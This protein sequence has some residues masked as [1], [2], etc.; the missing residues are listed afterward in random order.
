MTGGR[1]EKV[2]TVE[3]AYETHKGTDEEYQ[4]ISVQ[5]LMRI[6][7]TAVPKDQA[8]WVLCSTYNAPDGR[9]HRAQEERGSFVMVAVDLDTGNVQGKALV[10][11]VQSFTGKVQMRVYSSSS[12]TKDERK[13]RVLI[14]LCVAHE[15]PAWLAITTALNEHILESIGVR[16]D[17]ALERAGQPI[18]LPN[19]APRTDGVAPLIADN[20]IEGPRLDV[21][22][23][24][25]LDRINAVLQ[26]ESERQAEHAKRSAEARKRMAQMRA[27]PGNQDKSVISEFNAANDLE[28]VLA[29]CGYRPG[30]RGGWKSPHQQTASYATKVFDEPSGQYWVSLSQ[31]DLAAGVGSQTHDGRSCFGDAFDVWAFH[32]HANNRTQAIKAAADELG[33]KPPPTDIDRLAERIRA[34]QLARMQ[35]TATLA[36]AEVAI[37]GA[38][39]AAV[40]VEFPEEKQDSS[41][42]PGKAAAMP[43]KGETP[44][45]EEQS[46]TRT[47]PYIQASDL[48]GWE[49]PREL[50]EG[51]L[52]EGGMTVI[53]GDSNTGKSFL[54][55]DMAAHVSL[56]RNWFGRRVKQGAVVYLAAESP[57]SIIDRSRALADKIGQPLDNLFITNCPI[58]LHDKNGDVLAVVNTI[59][60]IEKRYG[61]KVC[62]V[63]ADTL[64]RVMGAGDEN[65]TKDMGVLVQHVDAIRAAIGVQFVLIHHTGKDASKGA[66]G[67]SALRAA[68]DTEIEVSDPGNDGPKEFKVTKQ[69]DLEGKGEVYGFTLS[70]VKLGVGVFDN[71]VTT[72]Y[73]QQAEPVAADPLAGLKDGE[74]EIVETIRAS[75]VGGV[76]YGELVN[77]IE[78]VSKVT[79]KRY[80]RSLRNKGLI[81]EQSGQYRL[82]SGKD[83]LNFGISGKEF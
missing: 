37:E 74:L 62:M 3:G 63:V 14:P 19:T 18:Y 46:I 47:L 31:S 24:P 34:N 70:S 61:V 45:A 33:I 58:D 17:Q 82:G 42:G 12:A 36:A 72:C 4:T 16:P 35:A 80:I 20:L 44:A 77:A 81:Y 71:V 67:S 55:L 43:V 64:A 57:R 79:V 54:T 68:T 75:P 50:I 78:G 26:R 28:Q 13:W 76:R 52:I 11:A 53:Y 23:C 2:L 15:F 29:A 48:P 21:Y 38:T 69:R 5:E 66:R 10:A 59:D 51:M 83:G 30:P 60:A 65:A 41:P 73:V 7:R 32:M 9:S 6:E 27:S 40:E 56:G 25:G 1:E 22:A 49:A 39:Q 8:R